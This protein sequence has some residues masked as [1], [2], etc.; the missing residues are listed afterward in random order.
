MVRLLCPA[1]VD[2][3]KCKKDSDCVSKVCDPTTQTCAKPTCSD[4]VQNGNE[5][6]VDC[7][8]TCCCW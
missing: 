2:T 1:C 4:K 5:I 6:G 3:K 8:G 7:G